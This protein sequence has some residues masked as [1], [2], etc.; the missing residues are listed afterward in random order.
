MS[1]I[2]ARSAA[3]VL[4]PLLP[5]VWEGRFGGEVGFCLGRKGEE[6]SATEESKAVSMIDRPK[7]KPAKIQKFLMR[8]FLDLI[9]L[10]DLPFC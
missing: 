5:R 9:M 1:L 4:G 2:F 8:V 6:A 3:L 10:K 7:E